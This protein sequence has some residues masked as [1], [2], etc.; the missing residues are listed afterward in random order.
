M[1]RKETDQPHA[2]QVV[3]QHYIPSP[4]D[5]GNIVYRTSFDRRRH[6]SCEQWSFSF[7]G[8]RAKR[9]LC[10]FDI[11]NLVVLRD[12]QG[13]PLDRVLDGIWCSEDLVEF[14]ELYKG[15]HQSLKGFRM[16]ESTYSSLASLWEEKVG[17]DAHEC[18]PDDEDDVA[19]PLDLLDG[20][21]PGELIDQASG[22]DEETLE[23]HTLGT[24]LVAEHLDGV[25][26]LQRCEV[27]RVDCA[28]EE[29]EG[30][31]GVASILVGENGVTGFHGAGL[32]GV[33]ERRC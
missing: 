1:G 17:N 14:L 11:D 25:Q 12:G 22:V 6:G 3:R 8:C 21:R 18:T 15:Q 29:D 19:L 30:Q 26:G 16:V 13:L 5:K 7:R 2:I 23:R 31:H 20:D 4:S 28:E 33:G 10:L 9:N 32:Q 27:E 24:D